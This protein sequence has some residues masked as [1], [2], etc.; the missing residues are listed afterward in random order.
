MH[1]EHTTFIAEVTEAW[2]NDIDLAF[3]ALL[4]GPWGHCYNINQCLSTIYNA[5]N[6]G[7]FD[8]EGIRLKSN[9]VKANESITVLGQEKNKTFLI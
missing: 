9:D 1:S 3:V 2:L 5:Q 6:I 7:R 8:S 4:C